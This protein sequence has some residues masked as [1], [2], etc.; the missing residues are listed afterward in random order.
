MCFVPFS[1]FSCS[2]GDLQWC[3][4]S[5]FPKQELF[6]R[7]L[8]TQIY[9]YWPTSG[10][11]PTELDPI[12]AGSPYSCVTAIYRLSCESHNF[13]T[14]VVARSI[15]WTGC[16]LNPTASVLTVGIQINYRDNV[17]MVLNGV[18]IARDWTGSTLASSQFQVTLGP[19]ACVPLI[20]E[21]AKGFSDG[22]INFA[23]NYN[24]QFYNTITSDY[25]R[26]ECP[27]PAYSTVGQSPDQAISLIKNA[28]TTTYNT[29]THAFNTFCLE[30]RGVWFNFSGDGTVVQLRAFASVSIN[31]ATIG[32]D[33]VA[34]ATQAA[35]SCTYTNYGLPATSFAVTISTVSTKT[36]WVWVAAA[37]LLTTPIQVQVARFISARPLLLLLLLL[38]LTLF[39]NR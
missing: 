25:L 12:F 20:V 10:S 13:A 27:A 19:S 29:V 24:S 22:N 38:L 21:Y 23:W 2:S 8:N 3:S 31:L 35:S 39:S 37:N 32:A 9:G 7:A 18:D 15:R 30:G 26:T 28:A 14:P 16:L 6:W 33:N 5:F 34:A 36:Y 4:S 17:R 1:R 11:G